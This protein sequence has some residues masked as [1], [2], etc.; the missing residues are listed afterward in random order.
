[1]NTYETTKILILSGNYQK[2]SMMKKLDV[3][4][5]LDRITIEEYQELAQLMEK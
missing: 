2:E 1:M 5:S 4:L 3:F